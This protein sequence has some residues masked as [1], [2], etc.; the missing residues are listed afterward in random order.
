MI[1]S[2]LDS[3]IL[4]FRLL[5]YHNLALVRV[6]TVVVG[7]ELHCDYLLVFYNLLS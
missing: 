7:S 1:H 6:I 5:V 3:I 4:K 2:G